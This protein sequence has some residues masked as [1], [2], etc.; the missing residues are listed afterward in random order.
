MK[1][2]EVDKPVVGIPQVPKKL[3]KQL[4]NQD[5]SETVY[6]V[7]KNYGLSNGLATAMNFSILHPMSPNMCEL[8]CKI[9]R[10]D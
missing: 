1:D 10:I 2:E 9:E 4:S 7:D 6:F 8:K 3:S 5:G